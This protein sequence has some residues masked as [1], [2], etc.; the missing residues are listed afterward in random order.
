MMSVRRLA[1]VLL[2]AKIHLVVMIVCVLMGLLQLLKAVKVSVP[3][4]NFRVASYVL[5]VFLL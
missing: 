5:V 2:C 3:N 1:V 4:V